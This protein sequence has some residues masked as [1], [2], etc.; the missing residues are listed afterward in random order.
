MNGAF[1]QM[2]QNLLRLEFFQ[3]MFPFLLALAILYGVL[4]WA[5]KEQL[6][7]SA[8]G[9]V[10]IIFAFFVMLY[11]SIN[12]TLYQF[13]TSISGVWF[14]VASAILFLIVLFGLVG[15]KFGEIE[16][17]GWAKLG[18]ALIIIYIVAVLFFNAMPAFNPQI[19]FGSDLWAVIFFIIILAVVLHY[20]TKE[21]KKEE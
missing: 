15:L 17:W 5:L 12:P 10:S 7:P 3:L 11:S 9:L 2:L 18:I 21:E 1:S 13:L 20:L 19:L 16:K 8:R 14:I 4:T 6:P